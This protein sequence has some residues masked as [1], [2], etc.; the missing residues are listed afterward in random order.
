M[1]E[2]SATGEKMADNAQDKDVE[3]REYRRVSDA[4]ALHIEVAD[5]DA[6]NESD[7]HQVEL[8][9]YP[10]HVVSL[11]PNGLKC[12]HNEAFNNGEVLS[13]TIRLFPS[14]DTITVRG[15]VVN[16]GEDKQ[17]TSTDRFFAGIAFKGMNKEERQ[18][19]LDHIDA[20]AKKSFGGAVKLVYK[21]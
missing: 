6:A 12:F 19:I 7:I 3:R 16:S 17:K 11:S 4:I 8:P 20:V 2:R 21:Q 10:T 14:G 5:G 1:A 15:R 13:L 9:D 18:A